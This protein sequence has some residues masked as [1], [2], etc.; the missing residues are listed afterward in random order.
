MKNTFKNQREDSQIEWK[1]VEH[2]AQFNPIKKFYGIINVGDK[3]FLT[4]YESK[5][6]SETKAIFEEEARIMGGKLD[7]IG[8][9]K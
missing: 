4:E 8:V 6:R 2:D 7:V 3:L 5:F 1:N 9:Y